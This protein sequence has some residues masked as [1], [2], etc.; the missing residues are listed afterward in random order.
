M[1]N[2]SP[3]FRKAV[4]KNWRTPRDREKLAETMRRKDAWLDQQVRGSELQRRDTDR[5]LKDEMAARLEP[6]LFHYRR[7]GQ[8]TGGARRI[9]LSSTSR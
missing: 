7:K 5:R 8:I 4:A 1:T 9:Q 2:Q 3:E 6:T